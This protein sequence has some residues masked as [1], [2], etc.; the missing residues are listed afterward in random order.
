MENIII[1]ENS[2]T[3][4]SNKIVYDKYD[5]EINKGDKKVKMTS[6]KSV[7][8]DETIISN[9]EKVS[10]IF[11][12]IEIF[13][14]LENIE[15]EKKAIKRIYNKI[16]TIPKD[17]KIN[18]YEKLNNKNLKNNLSIIKEKYPI[19]ELYKESLY[20]AELIIKNCSDNEILFDHLCVNI[21]LDCSSFIIPESKILSIYYLCSITMALNYLEIPYSIALVADSK[22]TVIIKKFEDPHSIENLQKIMECI[23]IKRFTTK[24]INCLKFAIDNMEYKG[25]EREQRCIFFFSNGMD[26]DLMLKEQFKELI[27]NN[28]NLSFGLIFTYPQS[29]TEEQIKK[30]NNM[31]TE[32]ED[33]Y[34][35]VNPDNIQNSTVLIAKLKSKIDEKNIKQL[36]LKITDVL[37]RTINDKINQTTFPPIFEIDIKKLNINRQIKGIIDFSNDKN[38]YI[39]KI[40][41]NYNLTQKIPRIFNSEY[42]KFIGK[43]ISL[44]NNDISK[45]IEN[46]N[47]YHNFYQIEENKESIGIFFDKVF[48][49]NKASSKVLTSTGYEIDLNALVLYLLNPISEPKFYLEEKGGLIRNYCVSIVLDTSISCLNE[50]SIN[51]SIQT[52]QQ[53]L[54]GL[55]IY[56]LPSFDMILAGEKNPIVLCSEIKTFKILNKK[57]DLWKILYLIL[58]NPVKKANLSSALY[59]ALEIRKLKSSNRKSLIFILTD[60]LFEKEE[61]EKIKIYSNY[62]LQNGIRVIC[63]GIGLYPVKIN[64]IFTEVIYA[65][66]PNNLW[67]GISALFGNEIKYSKDYLDMNINNFNPEKVKELLENLL[68]DMKKNII[69]KDLKKE[70]QDIDYELDSFD[71]FFKEIKIEDNVQDIVFNSLYEKDTLKGNKILIVMLWSSELSIKES[72]YILKEYLLTPFNDNY[73]IKKNLCLKDAAEFYGIDLK[74]VLN[75]EDAIY[76]ITKKNI[77]KPGFCNYYAVWIFCGPPYAILPKQEEGNEEKNNPYLIDQ[78]IDVLIKFW[79]NEGNLFFLAEGGELHYQLDLFLK[80][81]KFKNY[82][83]INIEII[84]EHEG[85]GELTGIITDKDKTLTKG[86]FNKNIQLYNKYKRP[87]IGHNIY[88]LY[89]GETISYIINNPDKIKPFIPFAV[90]NSNGITSLFYCAEDNYGDIVIDCGFTKCFINMKEK[91]TYNYFQNIIGWMGK[92]EIHSISSGGIE[93]NV[94]RPKSVEYIID[95]NKKFIFEKELLLPHKMKTLFAIDNSGS[96]SYNSFYHNEVKKIF[97]K[98]YKNGDIA[99]FWNYPEVKKF[100]NTSEEI[101][102]TLDDFV[103]SCEGTGGTDSELIANI[104]IDE[105]NYREHLLIVTDGGVNYKCVQKTT[106]K[107]ADKNIKFKFVSTF[108]IGDGDNLS[109]GAPFCRNC[110]NITY[111]IKS[112]GKK[113]VLASLLKEDLESLEKIDSLKNYDEFIE[114]FNNLEKA[115]QAKMIGLE[116]DYELIKKLDSLNKRLEKTINP[117]KLT[118][119]NNKFNILNNWASGKYKTLFTIDSISAAKNK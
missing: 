72:D 91:G 115:I 101:L 67:K 116:P 51:H 112:N 39:K 44:K 109:V 18:I 104:I 86:T 50:L 78:F 16:L 73:S 5:K 118:D 102:K 68:N 23:M 3:K 85:G 70:L 79:E 69:F 15:L 108:I 113:K 52:I 61:R 63:I 114:H 56:N 48:P 35:K 7:Y 71:F 2:N 4:E 36:S 30:V 17:N 12:T 60:G 88:K 62:C 22:F 25:K 90:D 26:E 75:Y 45:R 92:P 34:E 89:E 46:E 41:S 96:V 43:F 110:E 94:W 87:S 6:Y 28:S 53:L 49:F 95:K 47:G 40:K 31:W 55:S 33:F 119:Y 111:S 74:I 66:S 117:E 82:G 80:K 57:E 8:K 19:N 38:I 29:L 84:D 65:Y 42:S 59:T 107:L 83:K 93:T 105:P 1:K 21:L 13:F 37:N 100:G 81:A 20:L 10:N 99:Y 14:A 97:D 9:E 24:I 103:S 58:K 54:Y 64:N 11:N 76:E 98:Y 27:F 77:E 106:E 32:F